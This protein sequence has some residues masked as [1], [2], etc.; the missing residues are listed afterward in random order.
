VATH[1][2]G[3]PSVLRALVGMM[4]DI[5]RTALPIGHLERLQDQLAAKMVLHRPTDYAT[6]EGID[7][8][9]EVEK[10]GAGGNVGDVGHPQGTASC[11]TEVALHQVG[12]RSSVG[13]PHRG[14][15]AFATTNA[16]QARGAHQS[17]HALGAHPDPLLGELGVHWWSAVAGARTL[18]QVRVVL[19]T[20]RGSTIAPCV[21]AAGGDPQQPTHGCHRIGGPIRLHEFESLA[22]L[23]AE[24]KAK[25]QAAFERFVAGSKAKYPKAVECLVKDREL[26]VAL[27]RLSGRA[28]GAHSLHQ[29]DRVGV[30]HHPSSPDKDSNSRRRI[31]PPGERQPCV[32]SWR[33]PPAPSTHGWIVLC[34]RPFD[35]MNENSNRSKPA[36]R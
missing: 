25:A 15:D 17:R 7:H 34:S 10:S 16:L 35:K 20:R 22:G 9:R 33:S 27:L 23:M 11:G 3:D 14:V 19:R 36:P 1:A 4:N 8:H 13:A 26:L 28:L 32:E 21:E 31:G 30:C 29:R 18:K 2:E 12:S 24:T 6:T 5:A